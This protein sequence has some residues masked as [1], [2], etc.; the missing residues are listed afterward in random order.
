MIRYNSTPEENIELFNNTTAPKSDKEKLTRDFEET[1]G[2][3]F[4]DYRAL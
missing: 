2:E 3:L 1:V 4:Y